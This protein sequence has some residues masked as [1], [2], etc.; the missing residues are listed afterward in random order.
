LSVSSWF[1]PTELP[2]AYRW[3]NRWWPSRRLRWDPLQGVRID[4]RYAPVSIANWKLVPTMAR[5]VLARR[6]TRPLSFHND[7]RLTVVIPYRD[8]AEHLGILLPELTA[9]LKE[10]NL[11]YRILV[12]EQEVGALFNRGRLLNAGMQYAAEF[13]DYYCFHDVDAVPLLANYA[14]PSQPLRLVNTVLNNADER[15]HTT[16]YFSGAIN[17]RKEQA[18]AVNGF[19]NEYWGWGKED[20]DFYFRLLLS[21][22]VCYFDLKGTFRDLPNP[23][24]QC[25][26]RAPLPPTHVKLN[27]RRRSL[28]LR[29]LTVPADDGVRTLKFDIVERAVNADYEHITVRW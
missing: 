12:V 24:H 21:G 16:H 22:F 29:G 14:C 20:D 3:L 28:L 1:A 27:R 18:F 6:V 13:T 10:Q 8:R 7:R 2:R 11:A 9:R 15:A 5:G 23:P 25:V 17:I 19:S 4:E 26:R